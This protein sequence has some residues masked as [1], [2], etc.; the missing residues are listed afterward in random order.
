MLYIG[1]MRLYLVAYQTHQAE[2]VGAA[3][4]QAFDPY[5]ARERAEAQGLHQPGAMSTVTHVERVP[6]ELIGRKLS[7]RDVMKILNASPKKPP[8]PSLVS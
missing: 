1:G 2:F 3:I 6:P 4:V 7:P 8:A 5:L